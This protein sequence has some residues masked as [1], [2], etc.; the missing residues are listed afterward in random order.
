M[1]VKVKASR[2]AVL[3]RLNN[4]VDPSTGERMRIE[5]LDDLK[6]RASLLD[7]MTQGLE[8]TPEDI[9]SELRFLCPWHP[10]T[11]PS[12]WMHENY[13]DTGIGRWGCNVCGISGDVFD[14][15]QKLHELT[16]QQAVDSVKKWDQSHNRPHTAGRIVVHLPSRRKRVG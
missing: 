15:V 7:V 5:S 12:L 13:H 3:R 6:R 1:K 14:F 10:D 8:Q 2:T 16:W 4:A 11:N 9:G